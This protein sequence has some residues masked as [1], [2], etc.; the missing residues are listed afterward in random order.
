MIAD[1]IKKELITIL[2]KYYN[3]ST[4][5]IADSQI[6]G[7]DINYAAKISTNH[8]DFFIKWNN[9]NKFPKM[10]EYEASGLEILKHSKSVNIPKIIGFSTVEDYSFL[11]LKFIN[12]G[13][14]M[15]DFW[16]HFGLKLAEMHKNTSDYFGLEYDNYIGN[17]N[18]SNAKHLSWSKFFIEERIEPLLKIAKDSNRI[19][20]RII[21]KFNCFLNRVDELFPREKPALLHGDL[22][23]GNYMIAEDGYACLI[24][25]AVYY[26]HREMDIAMSRLFGGFKNEFYFAYNEMFPMELAWEKRI[27]FYNLYPLLVHVNLFGG[28]YINSIE[29]I[30]KKF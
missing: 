22:W 29:S 19:N 13:R 6:F 8:G 9:A 26:G 14:I 11:I 28:G 23:N 3:S 12:Q 1:C 7:G 15:S 24:D 5:I 18:Q 17:L 2:K 27:D 10:F 21:S 4:L 20:Y 25:P 16:Q 30:L